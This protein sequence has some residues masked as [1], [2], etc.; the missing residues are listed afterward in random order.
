MS[1]MIEEAVKVKCGNCGNEITLNGDDFKH[2]LSREEKSL[3]AQKTHTFTW[4]SKC[5]KCGN[6]INLEIIGLEYPECV[7][8]H[9][10][11]NITGGI[12]LDKPHLKVA[13][14]R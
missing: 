12:L 7:Y 9:E 10:S 13:H 4:N 3:G 14:E 2:E 1:I 6:E 11:H 8:K 5:P